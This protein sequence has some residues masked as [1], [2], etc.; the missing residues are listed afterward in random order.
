M[1]MKVLWHEYDNL[2]IEND[3]LIRKFYSANGICKQIKIPKSEVDRL[4]VVLHS[5]V[6][7]G[8]ARGAFTLK[9]RYYWYGWFKD[10]SKCVRKCILCQQRKGPSR[11]TKSPCKKY[12]SSAPF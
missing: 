11:R 10:L 8:I 5:Q 6:H 2:E 1:Q 7:F 3:V 9:Q 4:L 12:L